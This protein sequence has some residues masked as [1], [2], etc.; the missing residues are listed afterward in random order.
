MYSHFVYSYVIITKYSNTFE[1]KQRGNEPQDANKQL[2]HCLNTCFC[3]TTI[4]YLDLFEN[5]YKIS[6][7][8]WNITYTRLNKTKM[9]T[10]YN[11]TKEYIQ[12]HY[13]VIKTSSKTVAN[14]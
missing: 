6:Y 12:K 2:H 10:I 4:T 1:I 9:Y 13:L 3:R 11:K 7:V 8:F 5:C 14:Q